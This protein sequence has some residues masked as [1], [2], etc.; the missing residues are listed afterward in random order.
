MNADSNTATAS[1]WFE[2]SGLPQLFRVFTI[3]VHPGKLLLALA[4]I[5]L[6]MCAGTVLDWVW[7]ATG[8]D[9]SPRE[10]AD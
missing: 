9:V 5:I 10:I 6:T 1:N 2:V 8:N 7:T 4:G 3:A